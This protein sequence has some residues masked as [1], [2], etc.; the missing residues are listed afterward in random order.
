MVDWEKILELEKCPE[1]I[2]LNI[3]NAISAL[4]GVT[5]PKMQFFFKNFMSSNFV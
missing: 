4:I 1:F 3:L 2:I 5:P